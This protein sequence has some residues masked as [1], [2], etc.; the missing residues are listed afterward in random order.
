MSSVNLSARRPARPKVS[1]AVMGA[2]VAAAALV[3][4]QMDRESPPS[5][6][7]NADDAAVKGD[8]W[9]RPGARSM[10]S[11]TMHNLPDYSAKAAGS[12]A[13]IDGAAQAL[14]RPHDLKV[15]GNGRLRINRALRNKL[16]DSIG[17]VDGTIAADAA[18][19]ARQKLRQE[20]SGAAVSDALAALD[21][22]VAYRNAAHEQTL[23]ATT[24]TL[25]PN[26]GVLGDVVQ[27]QRRM[28]LR[29]QMLDADM[30][31][32]FFGDEE[33]LERYR[34]TL[35]QLQS[36]PSLSEGERDEQLTPLWQQLPAHLRSQILAPGTAAR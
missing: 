13:A 16:D 24:P 30:R 3:A 32:E 10:G 7:T 23:M 20:L 34:L 28:A 22:Y 36:M 29:T 2:V 15:D 4:Y 1:V 35:L 5:V 27:L 12:L 18:E 21:R 33:A 8:F 11:E 17:R 9:Q 25:P 26:L 19:R 6:V 14:A 31:A